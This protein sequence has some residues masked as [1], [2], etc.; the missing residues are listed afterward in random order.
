LQIVK[1]SIFTAEE[2]V[3]SNIIIDVSDIVVNFHLIVCVVNRMKSMVIYVSI[4]LF[5]FKL[6]I[7][8]GMGHIFQF[9]TFFN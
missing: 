4:T 6:H 1:S 9:S 5:G 3:N 8:E 2:N 7:F